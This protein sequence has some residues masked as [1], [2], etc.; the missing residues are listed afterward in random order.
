MDMSVPIHKMYLPARAT[1]R[2][3]GPGTS[4]ILDHLS[5]PPSKKSPTSL[6]GAFQMPL[7]PAMQLPMPIPTRG[8]SSTHS[9]SWHRLRESM[10]DCL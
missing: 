3:T 8:L 10:A 4:F 9:S 6:P 7:Q 5:L 1:D 2:S